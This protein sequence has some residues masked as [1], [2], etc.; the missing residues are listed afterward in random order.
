MENKKVLNE[1]AKLYNENSYGETVYSKIGDKES[2]KECKG[3]C[4]ALSELLFSL[5]YNKEKDFTMVK[6]ERNYS[7]IC[8]WTMKVL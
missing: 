1:I 8:Y 3:A 6:S 4:T 7:K 2:E 5:G